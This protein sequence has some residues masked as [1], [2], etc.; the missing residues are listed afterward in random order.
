MKILITGA[1]GNIGTYLSLGLKDKYSL[2]LTDINQEKLTRISDDFQTVVL[3]I[4]DFDSCNLVISNVGVVIHL[5]GNPNPD[6]SFDSVLES[7]IK[8]SYNVFQAAVNNKV[9]KVI[10]ASSAQTIEAYP[11]DVQLS[12][13][14]AVR[15]KNLYGTSKVFVEALASYFSDNSA[16][17]FIGLRIGAFDEL[18]RQSDSLNARDL[19]AYLSP[20]DLVQLI[21][22]C[23]MIDSDNKFEVINAISNNQYKRLNIEKARAKFNYMP[24][25][26]AF[27]ESGYTFESD[28]SDKRNRSQ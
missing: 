24:L 28:L 20:R 1:S 8:G 23:I 4:E 11:E 27:K 26:D 21:D 14:D 7:N 10:F 6:A 16:T 3:D 25:D 2:T 22:N 12:E 18:K 5:A 13:G 9:S 17:S 19:S 15:P